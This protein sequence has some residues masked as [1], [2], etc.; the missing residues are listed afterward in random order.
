MADKKPRGYIELALFI[1]AETSGIAFNSDDP[2]H[3][4]VTGDT[5]QVVSLG[6]IVANAHTLK[7]I[8]E[9]YVEIKWDGESK[10]SKEAEGIHG[11]SLAYLE[12]HGMDEEE[13]VVE[14]ATLL[15]KYWG[16][17]SPVCLGGHNVA[18]FDKFFLRRLLR[19]HGIDVRFGAKMLDTNSVG[20]AT[21]ATHNSDDLFALV[22]CPDRD[23]AK[24]N[25]LQDARNALTAFRTVRQIFSRCVGE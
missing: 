2:S 20:F 13:A 14:I 6:L 21:F 1:D 24:H 19:K 7:P 17:D 8:E 12:E 11:L 22:G 3:D 18:S 15:L 23:P 5:Y 4:P 9:L 10:W 25:A 16:P